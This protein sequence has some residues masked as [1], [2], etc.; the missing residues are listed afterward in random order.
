MP[1]ETMTVALE[2]VFLPL[3]ENARRNLSSEF[4]TLSFRT[5]ASATGSRTTYQGYD[6]GIECAFPDAADHEANCVAAS[7]GLWHLDSVCEFCDFDVTWGVGSHPGEYVDLL[8]HPLA[9]SEDTLRQLSGRFS[10]LL[11]AFRVAVKL[12]S[13]RGERPN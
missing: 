3:F 10:E 2:N 7:V 13:R 12:W 1:I 11:A 9:F 6:V 5:W 8:G 4:P